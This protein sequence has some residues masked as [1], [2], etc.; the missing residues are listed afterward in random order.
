M[1]TAFM[2]VARAAERILM[3]KVQVAK[4][5]VFYAQKARTYRQR[6]GDRTPT[7][8]TVGRWVK[9]AQEKYPIMKKLKERTLH[10]RY[11]SKTYH[12]YYSDQA[13]VHCPYCNRI[14]N[15]EKEEQNGNTEQTD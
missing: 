14:L 10:C 4:R 9:V 13:E 5:L 11:C 1:Q 3:S 15:K 2:I 7:R 6:Y 8:R 12:G